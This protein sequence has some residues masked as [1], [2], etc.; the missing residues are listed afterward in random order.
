MQWSRQSRSSRRSQDG[1]FRSIDAYLR[2]K[3]KSECGLRYMT[4]QRY[5]QRYLECFEY[6]GK[7]G[8]NSNIRRSAP[9]TQTTILSTRPMYNGWIR[10]KHK[11]VQVPSSTHVSST[12]PPLY[13][14]L[15]IPFQ[16]I[17]LVKPRR[18]TEASNHDQ[19]NH[20]VSSHNSQLSHPASSHLPMW[21]KLLAHHK[22]PYSLRKIRVFRGAAA[23]I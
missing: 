22:V 14:S 19:L 11:Q 4:L 20:P 17:R 1:V 6:H 23:I 15:T 7:N 3:M 16:G 8:A 21:V 9:W 13:S 12:K 18:R 2:S 5:S 10:H